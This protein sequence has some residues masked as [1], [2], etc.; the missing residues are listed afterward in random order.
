MKKFFFIQLLLLPSLITVAEENQFLAGGNVGIHFSS[1]FFYSG[2]N[3]VTDKPIRNNS[4]STRH[5]LVIC[6][7]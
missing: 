6:L 2:L 7:E 1:Q 3:S 5:F 4:L